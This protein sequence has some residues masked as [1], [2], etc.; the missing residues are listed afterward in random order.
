MKLNRTD[1]VAF[2]GD[3]HGNFRPV[4]E[5]IRKDHPAYSIFLGDFDLDR[6]LDIELADLTS[7]GSSIFFIHG[8][9][10]ADRESWHDFVFESG[11]ANSNLAG[12]VVELDG[13]RVA[14]LGG[15]FHADV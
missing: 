3:P 6:P 10:D 4:R 1:S 5:L 8:N 9:H 14:G 12:P 7:V 11:L 2:F 13:V 15:V